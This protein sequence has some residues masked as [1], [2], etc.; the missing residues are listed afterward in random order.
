MYAFKHHQQVPAGLK[1]LQQ[2]ISFFTGSFITPI[3]SIG[4]TLFYYDQRIRMEGYD[5]EWMMQAA[6]LTVPVAAVEPAAIEPALAP[7]EPEA[8]HE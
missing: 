3:L 7:S 5:I 2:V 6:G 4:I 8:A 1:V